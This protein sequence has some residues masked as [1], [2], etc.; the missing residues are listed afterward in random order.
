MN[1]SWLLNTT[2]F[3]FLILL[4]LEEYFLQALICVLDFLIVLLT[5]IRLFHIRI[6]TLRYLLWI[7]IKGISIQHKKYKKETQKK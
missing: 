2:F 4:K 6:N 1:L 7:R 3:R 5:A